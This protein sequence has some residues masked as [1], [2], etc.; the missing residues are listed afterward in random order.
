M[1]FGLVLGGG[2]EVRFVMENAAPISNHFSEEFCAISFL[3]AAAIVQKP[4]TEIEDLQRG[5]LIDHWGAWLN[6]RALEFGRPWLSVS[7]NS[8]SHAYH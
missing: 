2:K 4:V 1:I 7:E 8:F 6:A 3:M 5:I